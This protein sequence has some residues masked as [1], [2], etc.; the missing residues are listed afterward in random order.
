M[1]FF[2]ACSQNLITIIL[3]L[4]PP[5]QLYYVNTRKVVSDRVMTFKCYKWDMIKVYIPFY[6]YNIDWH[7]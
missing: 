2:A 7:I 3:Q 6:R 1:Y 5:T 4:Y